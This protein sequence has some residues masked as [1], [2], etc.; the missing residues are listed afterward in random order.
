VPSDHKKELGLRQTEVDAV[1]KVFAEEHRRL[2][3]ELR[4][5]YTEVTGDAKGADTL[6]PE[7]LKREIEEKSNREDLKLVFQRLARERA[8]LQAPPADSSGLSALERM[9][10]LV[11]SSGDRVE[12]SIGA[13]IGDDLARRYREL[14][15][16]FGHSYRSSYGCP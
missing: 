16:G 2:T 6:A 12:R 5:I 8:G 7:S 9:Y 11:T 15:H 10:R 14:K 1:N 13:E 4:K 3:A